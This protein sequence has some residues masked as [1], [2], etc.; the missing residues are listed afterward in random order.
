MDF[1]LE[2][3]TQ[4]SQ[5]GCLF[6]A[7]VSEL[8]P[9][10]SGVGLDEVYAKAEALARKNREDLSA[11][12]LIRPVP[13]VIGNGNR[14]YL[15]DH[16]HLA[17]AVWEVAQGKNEA[18]IDESNARVVVEVVNNWSVLKDYHFWKAM[19]DNRWV[20]L[21]DHMGGGPLQP[22]ALP[23]HIKDLRNDPPTI[24]TF[25]YIIL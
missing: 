18:G 21:F 10:Q 13:V 15:T 5:R 2:E 14:L 16:H 7:R 3:C 17:R 1:S 23:K 20:Y 8:R 22:A 11:F 25:K 19:H 4:K 12:L 6:Q 9:T 24:F